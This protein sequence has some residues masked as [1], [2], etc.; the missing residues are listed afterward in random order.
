M[1][2][3]FNTELII[4]FVDEQIKFFCLIR[5]SSCLD[6]FTL[7]DFLPLAHS[8]IKIYTSSL[9]CH[10]IC[11][12]FLIFSC[13]SEALRFADVTPETLNEQTP[14]WAVVSQMRTS[15]RSQFLPSHVLLTSFLCHPSSQRDR[16]G[17]RALQT[18][19]QRGSGSLQDGSGNEHVRLGLR[20][21]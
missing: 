11:R 3:N 13:V 15:M 6:D 4:W 16:Y 20:H 5:L 1:S 17:S 19:L 14:H 18:G 7:W 2:F 12:F 9:N 10:L 8:L 21:S